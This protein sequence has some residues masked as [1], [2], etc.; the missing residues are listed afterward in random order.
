[1]AMAYSGGFNLEALKQSL[2]RKAERTEAAVIEAVEEAAEIIRDEAKLNVPVDTHNL[3][4]AIHI[5]DRRTRRGNHAVDVEVSGTG[6]DGRDVAEYAMEVHEHYESYSPGEGTLAKRAANP[7]RYIGEK[8]LE[9]AVT[10][11]KAEA[12]DKVRKAVREAVNR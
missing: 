10:D 11:K 8:Y 3:E 9:R 5:S 4:S 6:D 1:M 12:V 2:Y 7:G